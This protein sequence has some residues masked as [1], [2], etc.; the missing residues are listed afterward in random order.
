MNDRPASKSKVTAIPSQ[1][2]DATLSRA[3]AEALAVK[4]PDAVQAD[5]IGQM[6]ADYVPEELP[7]LDA[8]ALGV[9]LAE[10]WDFAARETAQPGIRIVRAGRSDRLDVV[11]GDRPFLVDSVMGEIA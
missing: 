7:A 10:L 1:P 9:G 6:A 5:F 2:L 4:A 11:Q 8:A 3:F